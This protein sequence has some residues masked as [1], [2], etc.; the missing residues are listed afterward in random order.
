MSCGILFFSHYMGKFM[1]FYYNFMQ[2]KRK[3]FFFFEIFIEK[4]VELFL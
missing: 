1:M 4:D 3:S 2:T